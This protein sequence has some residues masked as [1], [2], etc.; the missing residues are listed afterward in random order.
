MHYLLQGVT[1]HQPGG[2]VQRDLILSGGRL[3]FEPAA[4]CPGPLVPVSGLDLHLLPG[5]TD[6]HVH[7]REP[8]FSYKETI[9]T[10][11]RAAARGG[12][13]TV[14]A[15]PNLN[16]VP[17]SLEHLA[18]QL[19]E[20]KRQAQV[21]VL[22]LGAITTGQKG[23]QLA[24]LE[25]MAPHV[26]GFSDDGKG[27]QSEQ[28]M[29]M[30]MERAGAL[31]KPIVAHCE[32]EALLTGG[33]IHEGD[34]AKA[35]GH[36]GISSASEWAQV[37]RDLLLAEQ[38]GCSYHVCHISTRETVD[39]IR[40]A[41]ARGVCVT[42]ET[43]PHYLVLDDGQLQDDG[44]FKM[45]PPI[46]SRADREA[47]VAGL[48]DGTIDMIATDHAPH[49]AQ[50]KSGGLQHSLNGV[51]GLETVFPVLYT[52]L[53]KT[54]ILPM[55]RLLDAMAY[56]PNQRFGICSSQDWTLF[57]LGA[58]YQVDPA[59]FLT[60]GRASPFTG[61]QVYGKCLLTAAGG[62]IAWQDPDILGGEKQP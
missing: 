46:R 11:T 55:N 1:I 51:V 42:C 57:N 32:D 59:N 38:T 60:K 28:L 4:V 35:H 10:G 5:F 9:Y 2:V 40:R 20:I 34:W 31:G 62:H 52:S 39:L 14:I 29:R 61:M 16:P 50:E 18:V 56:K 53:V 44:R 48:K 17:D 3:S 43:A 24:D 26:A 22:P 33:W 49:S 23:R 36:K 6:V 19:E 7:L 27:V 45:N 21:R 58:S 37:Q 15:M 25:A 30:A 8:G 12:V 13:T 41:K 47:L 54:G